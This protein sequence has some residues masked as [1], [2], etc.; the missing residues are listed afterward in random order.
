MHQ[1]YNWKM[2]YWKISLNIEI[3]E[4]KKKKNTHTSF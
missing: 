2:D 3:A 1:G 4:Y